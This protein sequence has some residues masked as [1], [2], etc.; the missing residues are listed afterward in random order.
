MMFVFS[1]T[2]DRA[3]IKRAAARCGSAARPGL[4]G[5]TT[6]QPSS[7]AIIFISPGVRWRARRKKQQPDERSACSAATQRH[8]NGKHLQLWHDANSSPAYKQK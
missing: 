4:D 5:A 8:I 2:L 7:P 1:M 3:K 6:A